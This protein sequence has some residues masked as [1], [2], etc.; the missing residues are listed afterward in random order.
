VATHLFQIPT[1]SSRHYY[2]WAD[3]SMKLFHVSYI[4]Q[5]ICSKLSIFL[6]FLLNWSRLSS[7]LQQ[8]FVAIATTVD[9]LSIGL[10]RLVDFLRI[11]SCI[12][13]AIST[14][15]DLY[16]PDFKRLFDTFSIVA[17]VRKIGPRSNKIKQMQKQNTEDTEYKRDTD[18]RGSP[19]VVY[20]HQRNCQVL[21]LLLFSKMKG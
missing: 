15:I 3:F 11:N 19:S 8:N 4:H 21:P 20:V 2:I 12:F 5:K 18:L 10:Q 16:I 17:T 7:L 6:I 1:G 13:V 14:I 9:Y